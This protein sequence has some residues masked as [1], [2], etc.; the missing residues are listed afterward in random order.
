MSNFVCPHCGMTN[1]DCGDEGYKT[2]REIKL[3]KAIRTILKALIATNYK[4]IGVYK[5]TL[6]ALGGLENEY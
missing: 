1:I 3:E 5:R 4:D 6:K 2:P